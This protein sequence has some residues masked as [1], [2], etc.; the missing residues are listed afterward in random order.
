MA[1]FDTCRDCGTSNKGHTGTYCGNCG[2]S[3]VDVEPSIGKSKTINGG[4]MTGY[5]MRVR[6]L[7]AETIAEYNIGLDLG[8]HDPRDCVAIFG[9]D[10]AECL[11]AVVDLGDEENG[12]RLVWS[13]ADGTGKPI[14]DL[15]SSKDGTAGLKFAESISVVLKALFPHLNEEPQPNA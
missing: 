12:P 4:V 11:A 6:Q 8:E 3:L 14:A 13:D 2:A 9:E 15:P 7:D 1:R 10:L 5:A